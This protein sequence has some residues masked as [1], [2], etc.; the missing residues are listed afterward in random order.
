MVLKSIFAVTLLHT[1]VANQFERIFGDEFFMVANVTD[2]SRMNRMV[3][4]QMVSLVML[5]NFAFLPLS[6]PIRG[7]VD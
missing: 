1:N 7:P 3:V 6:Q 2:L 4:L 5:T